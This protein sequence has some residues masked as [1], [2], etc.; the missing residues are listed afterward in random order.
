MGNEV[1]AL[2]AYIDTQVS[3]WLVQG[4]PQKLSAAAR[5]AV[6]RYRLR[7]SPMVLLEFEYLYE[8]R[9]IAFRSVQVAA[10]LQAELGVEVC[11]YPFPKVAYAALGESWTRDAFD[12]VIVAQAKANAMAPL[13]TADETMRAHYA[14]AVW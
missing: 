8:I 1:A 11:D 6:D 5:K 4:K 12:R 10:K 3:L 9:R 13:I 2:I 7:I 14:P